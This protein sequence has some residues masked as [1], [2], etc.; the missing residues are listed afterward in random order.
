MKRTIISIIAILTILTVA[1]S[2]QE[3]EYSPV[4]SWKN[5]DTEVSKQEFAELTKSN[6][7]L[8]YT[9][10]EIVIQ[11]KDA[12]T[13][14]DTGDAT[15]YFVQNAYI[16]I[17]DAKEITKRDN[18]TK[19][20]LLTKYAGAAQSIDVNTKE[21]MIEAFFITGPRGYGELRVTFDG[22]TLKTMTNT[23]QE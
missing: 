11:D 9:D 22:D 10:G 1:C 2:H 19:E 18:W 15:T 16:P 13:R 5:E 8:E 12:V 20:E 21:N 14:S 7:A 23:F 6:N 3:K 4:T 17:T